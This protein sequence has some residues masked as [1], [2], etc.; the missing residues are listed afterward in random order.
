[1]EKQPPPEPPTSGELADGAIRLLAEAHAA[2]SGPQFAVLNVR[3]PGTLHRYYAA[4]ATRHCCLLLLEIEQAA[5]VD[6]ETTVTV[7]G[8]VYIEAW[9]TALYIHFGGHEALQRVAQDTAYQV[10]LTDNDLKEFD[11]RLKRAK[12]NAATRVRKVRATNAGISGRNAAKPELPP[13][14]LHQEPRIPQLTPTGIDISQRL[15]RDLAG[16]TPQSLPLSEITDRLTELGPQKG[17]ALESLRPV[18]ILYRILSAGAVH[19]NL[20][21]YDAYFQPGPMFDRAGPLPVNCVPQTLGTR[22]T[23]LY[24][25]AFLL[26]WVLEDAGLP[27]PVATEIRRWLEPDPTVQASWAPG[28]PAPS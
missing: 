16:I 1:M 22:I 10:R 7:L 4:A 15:T 14:P 25:A 19:A 6:L 27:A 20:N 12:K 9:L 23:V 26:G 5:A 13:R 24:S 8:R 2:L 21:V 3:T 18:Y 17:F 28:T 11:E